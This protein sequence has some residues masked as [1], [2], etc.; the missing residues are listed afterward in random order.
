M[1]IVDHRPLERQAGADQ[2]LK[3]ESHGIDP[4][5]VSARKGSAL[6][7]G[8]LWVAAFANF[9]SLI[10][11][12]LLIGFGLGVAEAVLAVAVVAAVPSL[13]TVLLAVMLLQASR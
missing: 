10:T 13:F 8:W 7:V 3:V 12:A 2:F 6:D 9:V 5:P 1:S 4:I 11:G